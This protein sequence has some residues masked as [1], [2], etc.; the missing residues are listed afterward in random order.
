MLLD[1]PYDILEKLKEKWDR[2]NVPDK[3]Q[4]IKAAYVSSISQYLDHCYRPRPYLA[5]PICG[6]PAGPNGLLSLYPR[7]TVDIETKT[8]EKVVRNA[9]RE[10]AAKAAGLK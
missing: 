9:Q 2:K 4:Q 5:F 3:N 10:T 7:T 6:V 1:Y 8:L